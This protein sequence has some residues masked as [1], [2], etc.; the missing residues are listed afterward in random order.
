[1]WNKCAL[2]RQSHH[3]ESWNIGCLRYK[4]G[5]RLKYLLKARTVLCT[6]INIRAQKHA[7]YVTERELKVLCTCLYSVPSMNVKHTGNHV[8]GV[9]FQG[10]SQYI[11]HANIHWCH[12]KRRRK[13]S[14]KPF[15]KKKWKS[16][17]GWG[18]TFHRFPF[19]LLQTFWAFVQAL[20]TQSVQNQG[21]T[22]RLCFV[23]QL[24]TVIRGLGK[25]PGRRSNLKK[26]KV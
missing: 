19:L 20:F 15:F 2:K 7:A 21:V 23:T 26:V 16:K 10:V 6:E 5:A 1:M 12:K 17:Q 25:N 13:K 14:G 8:Y 9:C 22:R 4:N 24:C 3:H 11:L 18:G